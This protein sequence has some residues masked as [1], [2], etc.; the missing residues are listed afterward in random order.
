MLPFGNATTILTLTGAQFTTALENGFKPPCGDVAGG[1]GR[2]PQISGLKI[3]FHCNGIV[4]V[5]DT[6][7]EGRPRRGPLTPVGPTDT[8][9]FVTNDFMFTGGDGYTAFAQGTN[10]KQTGDLLLNVVIDYIT[11]HS[12]VA[13]VVEG[14][15]VKG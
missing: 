6:V 8:I 4:P 7:V 12:P 3:T 1:T 13:P 11:A 15:F 5:I 2:T 14:R 9:R 10:V